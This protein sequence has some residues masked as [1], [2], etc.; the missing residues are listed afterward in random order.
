MRSIHSRDPLETGL[1]TDVM[2]LQM[3]ASWC[4]VLDGTESGRYH[5]SLVPLETQKLERVQS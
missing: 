3:G 4:S 5:D 2:C 1:I